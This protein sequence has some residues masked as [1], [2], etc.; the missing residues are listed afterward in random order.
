MNYPLL[1]S[2][3]LSQASGDHAGNQVQAGAGLSPNAVPMMGK[4][5]AAPREVP[6]FTSG[7]L[8]PAFPQYIR[9]SK[10]DSLASWHIGKRGPA[11]QLGSLPPLTRPGK[12]SARPREWNSPWGNPAQGFRFHEGGSDIFNMNR[13]LLYKRSDTEEEPS[14]IINNFPSDGMEYADYGGLMDDASLVSILILL[15]SSLPIQSTIQRT[16]FRSLRLK[17]IDHN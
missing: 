15:K 17:F 8:P 13:N 12:K 3:L 5:D 2:L 7:Y 14:D 6:S 9:Q 11:T 4:K 10:R 1:L 16:A